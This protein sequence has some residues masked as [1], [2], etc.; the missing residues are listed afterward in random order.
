MQLHMK[1]NTYVTYWKFSTVQVLA[2]QHC[3]SEKLP[4]SEMFKSD[5]SLAVFFI[6]NKIILAGVFTDNSGFFFHRS[7]KLLS[8]L[9]MLHLSY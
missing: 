7:I 6:V 9:L 1:F 8:A 4:K 5:T 2:I 3:S